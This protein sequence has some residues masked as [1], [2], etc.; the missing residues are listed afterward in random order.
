MTNSSRQS[1]YVDDFNHDPWADDYDEDV[2]NEE[3]PIRTGY[4][5]VLDW[6]VAQ[7]QINPSD[8]VVDLGMGTGNTSERI[9]HA[10]ELIGVD[11]SKKMMAQAV[12]KVAHLPRIR[13]VEADLLGFFSEQQAFDALV[14]T[15]AI[16]HLTEPE[17]AQ[18]FTAIHRALTPGRRA[19]FGDLMFA[20]TNAKADLRRKYQAMDHAEVL[21]SFD[22]EFFWYIDH[23]TEALQTSG[24]SLLETKQFSDLSWGIAVE[25]PA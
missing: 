7:T 3:D 17:K 12:P 11:I 5:A 10:K 23:A 14:S 13:Y 22:E 20:D 25:K 24:F 19:V 15:Y 18:L 16:H 9:A 21:E 6:V 1:A 2:R 4:S 8:I